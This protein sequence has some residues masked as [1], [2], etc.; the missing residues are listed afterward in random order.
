MICDRKLVENFLMKR[1]NLLI[2]ENL[3]SL[4]DLC[5]IFDGSLKKILKKCI[6]YFIMHFDIC[7]VIS[8]I[9]FLFIFKFI[10]IAQKKV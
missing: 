4:K 10:R 9:N 2:K 5:E 6:I 3:F 1:E 7:E 8:I